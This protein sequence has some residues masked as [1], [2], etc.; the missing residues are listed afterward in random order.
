[1]YCVARFIEGCCLNP[2]EYVLDDNNKLRLFETPKEA[3]DLL[4]YSSAGEAEVDDIYIE[5]E[6]EG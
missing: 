5:D 6:N 1:M 2:K 4:G 3:L